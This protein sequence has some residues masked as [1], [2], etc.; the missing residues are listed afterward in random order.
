MV[1]PLVDG[2]S[3]SENLDV[4]AIMAVTRSNVADATVQVL[5]VVP[6]DEAGDP[7][8]RRV[9]GGETSGGIRVAVLE[10]S[11]QRFGEGIVVGDTRSAERR[12][13][14]EALKRC[15]HGG[16]LHR[17]A[18]VRMQHPASE[19]T[20][21]LG[22]DAL[23]ELRGEISRFGLV[24]FPA[25]DLSAPDI[26]DEIQVEELPAHNTAQIG[27][28]PRSDLPR[29]RCDMLARSMRRRAGSPSMLLK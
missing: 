20:L 5:L 13:D 25:E 7:H 10:G 27:D 22:A 17:A 28:V 19:V 11:K 29:S 15:E 12:H 6:T 21:G 16:T 18:V 14:A 9:D 4:A 8:A 2:A 3:S 24:H 1:C 23:D 26:L